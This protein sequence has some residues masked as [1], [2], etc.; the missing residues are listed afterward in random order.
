MVRSAG[1]GGYGDPL[2]ARTERVAQDVRE[3]YVSAAA[4]REL[5][6][7]VLDRAGRVDAVGHCRAAQAAAGCAR[8]AS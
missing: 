3:G 8:S 2:E 1:G 6:G 4:A 7:L 5:Y